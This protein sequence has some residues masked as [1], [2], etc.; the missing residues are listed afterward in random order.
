M[1]FECHILLRV[2]RLQQSSRRVASKIACHFVHFI[3]E[4]KGFELLDEIM[5]LMILPGI[6][7]IGAPVAAYLGLVAHAAQRHARIFAP[8]AGSYAARN[9]GFAHPAG[10]QGR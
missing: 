2:K 10:L 6:A 7:P 4:Q 5:A 9:R 8:Q 1:V 3:Q